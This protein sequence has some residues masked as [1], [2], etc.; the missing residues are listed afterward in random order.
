MAETLTL[1]NPAT[2]ALTVTAAL[3]HRISAVRLGSMRRPR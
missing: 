3:A 2:E 1:D